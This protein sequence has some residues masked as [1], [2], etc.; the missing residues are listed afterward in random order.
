M[1]YIKRA[2]LALVGLLFLLPAADAQYFGRNKA[3]YEKF[4]FKVLETP[5][6][7]MH[8]Y[9]EDE[10]AR[11]RLAEWSEKWYEM[12]QGILHDTIHGKN[13]LI[14]YNNHADFQQTNAIS[15]AVSI[16]TGGVTEALKNRVI[17]PIAMT[18]QQT[19]HV[20]GHEM[21]HA[22]QYNMILNG[23]STTIKNLG[24]LP[25]WMVEGLAEYM[26]I[27][28][29][30]AH[31]SMWMRDAVLNDDVP[32]LKDL[33]NYGKYFPYR[34]GQVFWAFVTG[35]KGDDII[36]PYFEETAK[37]GLDAATLKV[38]G[39][40]RENLS[41]LWVS[42]LKNH[43]GQYIGD[44]KENFIGKKI[45]SAENAGEMNIAPVISPNGRYV[46]FLSTKNLFT[47]DLFLADARNGKIIRTVA[48]QTR[49]GHI[50]DFNYIES[51][52]TWSPNSKQFAFVG[53]KKG[54]N[55]LIVK[56]TESGKTVEEFALAG[57]PAFSNPAWSPD[58]KTV[59]VSGLVDGQHDLYAVNMKTKKVTQLTDDI[60]SE[61]TPNWSI[62][63]K[64]IVFATDRNVMRADGKNT[65]WKFNLATLNAE[66]N[67]IAVVDVFSGA[68]NMNPVFDNAGNIIFLS[69]RDGFRNMYRYNPTTG[70]TVQMTDLITG[71]SGI[72]AF[73]PAISITHSERRNRLTF[74]HFYDGRYSIY[75]A[76]AENFESIP[77]A[78]DSVDMK[79]ATL[80]RVNKRAPDLV[81]ATLAEIGMQDGIS[82]D[83]LR[84]KDYDPKFK[85][86]YV[87]G[88][89]GVGVNSGNTF[90]TRTGAAGGVDMLFSDIL[91]NNQL[92][93]SVALNGELQDF[94]GAVAYIN[95]DNRVAWGASIS[96]QPRRTAY[97]ADRFYQPSAQEAFGQRLDSLSIYNVRLF[98]EQ[99][100]VFGQLPFSKTLRL[101]AGGSYSYYR[102]R[103]DQTDNFYLGAATGFPQQVAQDRNRIKSDADKRR[104]SQD[105]GFNPFLQADL[106]GLN[107]ALV[108]DNSYFGVAAPL[109]GHRF[110]LGIEQ[111]FNGFTY[112]ENGRNP[113]YN[114]ATVTADFRKYVYTKPVT[115]AGRILHTGR[116]GQGANTFFPEY[117]G[118]PWLVRGYNG[119]DANEILQQNG[120]TINDLLGSKLLV[121]NFEVRLPFTGPEKLA[122]FKNKFL[123]SDLNLFADGGL[124][125]SE[126][127]QFDK[128][129]NAGFAPRPVFS[130]GIS[131]RVNVFNA[132]IIEPFYAFPL[133]SNTRGVFGLN[134]TPGW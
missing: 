41:E 100:S 6:F 95:R 42:A 126:F 60:Y 85:L 76:L 66:T 13:P 69:N 129:E 59:A 133:Q 121:A 56:D 29:V 102:T 62:D 52:G 79:A 90:G 101:E 130:A 40:S 103:V 18:N 113:S 131:A 107:V 127:S 10:A 54:R 55:V 96:H 75:S 116:Y 23:D 16:G 17:L 125:W 99:V 124:A 30:D 32:T 45:L 88:G 31:T 72:T 34:W 58:G 11:N 57:V 97:L 82:A 128:G 73:A 9:L 120:R 108:G 8:H 78:A 71:I 26:S 5:H 61:L 64:Q 22:F 98:Q 68:D 115:F 114:F 117:L 21:V 123:F 28:R 134:F 43:Y 81:D 70:E 51:A 35:L 110:R 65:P 87:G 67:E 92:F 118:F 93:T 15:G 3:R 36:A 77:A 89:A 105:L 104:V 33:N 111:N 38:L 84:E 1:N 80:P 4:D 112:D 109:Q 49:D 86:D 7:E 44:N 47:T 46:I 37:I 27:G 14:Y 122:L 94:G 24:N 132:L 83:S 12:H 39:M 50:D 20:I 2:F 119:N 25:L 53:V 106:F 19:D 63:G 74:T 48:S 91:G